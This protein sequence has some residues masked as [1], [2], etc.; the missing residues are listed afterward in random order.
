MQRA[1][2]AR[3]VGLVVPECVADAAAGRWLDAA[4][5]HFA[6]PSRSG[7]AIGV[8]P[9]AE[10][11]PIALATAYVGTFGS[12]AL[13]AYGI[14]AR[15]EYILVPVT[16]GIGSALTAMVATNLGPASL[17]APSE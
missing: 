7:L 3:A 16:F 14:A 2:G 5:G 10:Q 11:R 15:L 9:G 13:A 6:H 17:H 8:G 1:R 4:V 12:V